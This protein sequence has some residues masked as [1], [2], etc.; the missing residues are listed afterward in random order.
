VPARIGQ[1]GE[2]LKVERRSLLAVKRRPIGP[3]RARPLFLPRDHGLLTVS[4]G[5][6]PRHVRPVDQPY[7][8]LGQLALRL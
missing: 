2:P 5:D 1:L 3:V 7:S 4:F 6:E 8:D